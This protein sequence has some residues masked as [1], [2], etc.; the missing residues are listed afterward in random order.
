MT[1]LDAATGKE[2][3]WTDDNAIWFGKVNAL[4][5]HPTEDRLAASDGYV[6]RVR[7][8]GGKDEDVDVRQ[9]PRRA[10]RRSAARASRGRRT[11]SSSR[12]RRRR[13]I[14]TC[15][16]S[17]S[18]RTGGAIP[19]RMLTGPKAQITCVAWSKDGKVIAAGDEDGY[20]MLW[21]AET[22]KELWR[23]QSRRDDADGRINALAISPDGQHR[24]DGRVAGLRQGAGARR[25]ACRQGRQGV[26]I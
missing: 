22:D 10:P 3:P 9:S 1:R 16:A 12:S 19:K 4:A 17:A 5:Y 15:G 25:A 2:D 21:D 24:R 18:A 6:T 20:V 26:D 14:R 7:R 23:K 13:G 11:E 8:L